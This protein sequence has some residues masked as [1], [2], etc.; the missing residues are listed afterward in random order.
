[1]LRIEPSSPR[2]ESTDEQI[3]RVLLDSL[4][5][6]RKSCRGMGK[7]RIADLLVSHNPRIR[8]GD[9]L[10]YLVFD[11]LLEDKELKLIV[12]GVAYEPGCGAL[13]NR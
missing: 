8:V 9:S 3:M 7:R 1:M 12:R 10:A 5:S 6:L 13:G 11:P 4:Q 2:S